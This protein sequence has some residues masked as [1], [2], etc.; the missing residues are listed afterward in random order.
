MAHSEEAFLSL[1]RDTAAGRRRDRNFEPAAAILQLA[2]FLSRTVEKRI[3][4]RLG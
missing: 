3:A 4:T 1:G 2:I